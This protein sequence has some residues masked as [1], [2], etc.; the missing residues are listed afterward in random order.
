M[1]T[2]IIAC[3]CLLTMTITLHTRSVVMCVCHLAQP[4]ECQEFVVGTVSA[5]VVS[6]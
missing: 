3:M 5:V 6:T 2:C 1:C 4:P